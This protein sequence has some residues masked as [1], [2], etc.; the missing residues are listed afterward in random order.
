MFKLSDRAKERLFLCG[1]P[2]CLIGHTIGL[3]CALLNDKWPIFYKRNSAAE[4][5]QVAGLQMACGAIQSVIAGSLFYFGWYLTGWSVLLAPS[6]AL[7][8]LYILMHVFYGF[9]D[10]FMRMRE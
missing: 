9:A 4:Y 7:F 2:F 5:I 3:L 10:A 6:I 1:Y 8:A